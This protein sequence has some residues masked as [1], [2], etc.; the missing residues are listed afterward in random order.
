MIDAGL[1]IERRRYYLNHSPAQ[2]TETDLS[3]LPYGNLGIPQP[4]TERI[5]T[6]H[7]ASFGI[8][9]ERPITLTAFT[10]NSQAVQAELQHPDHG[11]EK[12]T[13]QYII[14]CDGARSAVRR[15]LD[16]PFEGDH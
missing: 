1:W 14:G 4:E 13:F 8:A 9:I 2:D 15:I 5:L 12:A 16:I 10:Q 7:L 3:D 6:A 11:T